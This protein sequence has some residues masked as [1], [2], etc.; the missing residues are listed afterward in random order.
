MLRSCASA[1]WDFRKSVHILISRCAKPLMIITMAEECSL[2]VCK[3]LFSGSFSWHNDRQVR[4]FQTQNYEGLWAGTLKDLQARM[5]QPV[6]EN[7]T[8]I[9]FKFRLHTAY[10][11]LF[12]WTVTQI[13]NIF[14]HFNWLYSSSAR[15]EADLGSS[16]RM[17]I[18]L[19]YPCEPNSVTDRSIPVNTRS[20][21]ISFSASQ[22]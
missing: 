9:V 10:L 19:S 18:R 17:Q 6:K 15:G 16:V 20:S 11:I 3:I 8:E 21:V 22:Q 4:K 13:G 5:N 7:L 1:R 12:G 2:T 14:H